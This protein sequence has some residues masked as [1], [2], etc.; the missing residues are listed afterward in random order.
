MSGHNMLLAIA[1]AVRH[2]G[3]YLHWQLKH[4]PSYCKRLPE[5]VLSADVVPAWCSLTSVLLS[6]HAV[7]SLK[8]A[9]AFHRQAPFATTCPHIHVSPHCPSRQIP[10]SIK[11]YA[12]STW[13]C[14]GW[15]AGQHSAL[16]TV[17][18]HRPAPCPLREHWQLSPASRLTAC[19]W[20]FPGSEACGTHTV[21]CW[22]AVWVI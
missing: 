4:L 16:P 8:A 3:G 18:Q 22:G 7:Q 20:H 9:Q 2:H 6:T 5:I 21:V 14:G 11:G 15:S 13:P 19:S 12:V 1:L 17:W 10:S